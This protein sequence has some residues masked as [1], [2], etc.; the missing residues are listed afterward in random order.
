MKAGLYRKE[1]SVGLRSW[2]FTR[3]AEVRWSWYQGWEWDTTLDVAAVYLCNDRAEKINRPVVFYH[4]HVLPSFAD[5]W[6]GLGFA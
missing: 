5:C 1:Y 2:L 6:E 4:H 3:G